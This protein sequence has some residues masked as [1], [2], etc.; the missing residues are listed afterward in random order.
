MGLPAAQ[1]SHTEPKPSPLLQQLELAARSDRT[2]H[3]SGIPRLLLEG[4]ELLAEVEREILFPCAH[5]SPA[6]LGP[7]SPHRHRHRVSTKGKQMV[8]SAGVPRP[9]AGTASDLLFPKQ[10]LHRAGGQVLWGSRPPMLRLREW[11]GHC[12]WDEAQQEPLSLPLAASPAAAPWGVQMLPAGESEGRYQCPKEK[13]RGGQ[14]GRRCWR[15]PGAPGSL[16]GLPAPSLHGQT[17]AQ[18]THSQRQ[19]TMKSQVTCVQAPLWDLSVPQI[20][21]L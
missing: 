3:P 6:R 11:R 2:G 5:L 13:P 18:G 16:P 14:G 17:D 9:R 4:R 21:Y 7:G 12:G 10:P 8:W 20:P 15:P 1:V 19:T